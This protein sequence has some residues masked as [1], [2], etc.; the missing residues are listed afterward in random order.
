VREHWNRAA[1]WL[2]LAVLIK[3]YPLALALLLCALYPRRFAPRFGLCLAAGLLLPFA[4]QAPATVTEQYASWFRH[5]ADSTSL[6]RERQ[7]SLDFLLFRYGYPI[8]P[9]LFM[10][11]GLATGAGVLGLSLLWVR[12]LRD[13]RA[14]LTR[15]FLLFATW[16][17]LC[18]P[19]TESCTYVIMAPAI[20]WALVE[21]YERGE[22]VGCAVL[23]L[24]LFLMGPSTTD[25]VGATLR[26]CAYLYAA[27]PLGALLFLAHLLTRP[28]S[29][30]AAV[31]A[32]VPES[33]LRRAA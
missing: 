13:P 17:V 19:T 1:L 32:T 7:R 16:V 18:G 20:A 4:T 3:G 8:S 14:L 11:L 2:T 5:M 10:L 15:V 27:Q 6:M 25:L 9:R 30:P 31:G 29:A 33:A 26:H 23:A 21:A 12:R 22:W 24:S 28:R